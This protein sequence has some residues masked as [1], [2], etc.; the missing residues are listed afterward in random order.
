MLEEKWP[1][2][3]RGF[4]IWF[5]LL[6]AAFATATIREVFVTPHIGEFAAKA[7]ASVVLAIVIFLVTLA[8]F[9]RLKCRSYRD[10]LA[11]GVLWTMLT[12]IFGFS[13]GIYRGD[14]AYGL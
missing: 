1:F 14:N 7:I 4:K 13:M 11:V 2:M 9:P 10:C 12:L 6:A 3:A 8:V 5:L